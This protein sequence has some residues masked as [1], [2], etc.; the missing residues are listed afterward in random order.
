MKEMPDKSPVGKVISKNGENCRIR[1]TVAILDNS[2]N[3]VS[4]EEI[5]GKLHKS[6]ENSVASWMEREGAFKT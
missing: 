5:W 3:K 1:E 4:Y 6:L 2:L